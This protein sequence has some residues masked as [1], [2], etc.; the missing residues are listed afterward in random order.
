MI[1]KHCRKAFLVGSITLFSSAF[2]YGQT[3][4]Q[5]LETIKSHLQQDIKHSRKANLRQVLRGL[6]PEA[7]KAMK[8]NKEIRKKLKLNK[9]EV[10]KIIH[11]V[12][13]IE[14]L[15]HIYKANSQLNYQGTDPQVS[16]FYRRIGAGQNQHRALTLLLAEKNRSGMDGLFADEKT[17]AHAFENEFQRRSIQ[18]LQQLGQQTMP[19]Q[20]TAAS[21]QAHTTQNN[22]VK[23][24]TQNDNAQNKTSPQ[25]LPP[26]APARVIPV[27]AAPQTVAASN[28]SPRV[29]LVPADTRTPV[30]ISYPDPITSAITLAQHEDHDTIQTE[31]DSTTT[32]DSSASDS[33]DSQS[34]P[35]VE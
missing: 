4:I 11:V 17:G 23:T 22:Q 33:S 20:T 24:S 35:D 10:S 15:E 29:V 28:H 12:K 18:Y 3:F 2:A 34:F 31:D 6:S 30:E 13:G 9:K 19:A 21:E 5:R 16:K 8:A 7:R 14:Q 27:P 26:Q 25:T 1:T 32:T